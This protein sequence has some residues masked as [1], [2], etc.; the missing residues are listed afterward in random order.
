[1]TF[2]WSKTTKPRLAP[3]EH[4]N[5]V[6]TSLTYHCVGVM[7]NFHSENYVSTCIADL[8]KFYTQE[9]DILAKPAVVSVENNTDLKVFS[10][11]STKFNADVMGENSLLMHKKE[12]KMNV[13]M[14]TD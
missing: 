2:A 1:M 4:D 12:Y 6:V 9:K 13:C 10:D 14:V 3:K 5:T 11:A 7:T 8:A